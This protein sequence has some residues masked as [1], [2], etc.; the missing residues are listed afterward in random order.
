[1]QQINYLNCFTI[2]FKKDK[3]MIIIPKACV[4]KSHDRNRIRRLIRANLPTVYIR[5]LKPINYSL[6]KLIRI[7][8]I[9]L[10]KINSTNNNRKT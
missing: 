1:M 3:Y 2:S 6:N 7:M 4:K 8:K 9:L 5:F 10:H